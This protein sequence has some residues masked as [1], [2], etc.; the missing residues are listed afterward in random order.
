MAVCV[1]ATV[2]PIKQART[3][4]DSL[5]C[6]MKCVSIINY[7]RDNNYYSKTYIFDCFIMV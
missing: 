3:A 2:D 1:N 6:Y 4:M 5:M 7:H